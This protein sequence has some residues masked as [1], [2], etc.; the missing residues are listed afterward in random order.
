MPRWTTGVCIGDDQDPCG[1][2]CRIADSAWLGISG[3]PSSN[4]EDVL[5][6]CM[7]SV[8]AWHQGV[9]VAGEIGRHH[10]YF[11]NR[12]TV[13]GYYVGRFVEKKMAKPFDELAQDI[14]FD[15]IDMKEASY[16]AKERYAG[17]LA[18]PHGPKGE[19]PIE[20][21][22]TMCGMARTCYGRRLGTMQNSW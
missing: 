18:V 19:K 13:G 4:K 16:T 17:R 8:P 1:Q 20:S 22:A 6:T 5:S 15:P 11:P 2:V 21:V 10:T 9:Q 3:F 7:A 12:L 14:V